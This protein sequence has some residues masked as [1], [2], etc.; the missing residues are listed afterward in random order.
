MFSLLC[1]IEKHFSSSQAF[2]CSLCFLY[3]FIVAAL[4]MCTFTSEDQTLA[5]AGLNEILFVRGRILWNG[6]L[7]AENGIYEV[8]LDY[9]GQEMALFWT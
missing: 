3:A 9:F 2:N 4:N 1:E 7:V 8:S 6:W 5:S